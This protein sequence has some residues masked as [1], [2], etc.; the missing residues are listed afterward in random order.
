[1]SSWALGAG[2]GASWHKLPGPRGCF[3]SV[4]SGPGARLP[5]SESSMAEP[6]CRHHGWARGR[7][8]AEGPGELPAHRGGQTFCLMTGP[9]A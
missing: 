6:L 9:R 3:H 4:S 8:R 2:A 1:M 7:V 5:L